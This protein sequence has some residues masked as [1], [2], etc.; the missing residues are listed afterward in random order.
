[1]LLSQRDADRVVGESAR[2]P[3][4]MLLSQRNADR[5]VGEWRGRRA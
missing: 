5:V 2:A 1:M 4:L 3:G